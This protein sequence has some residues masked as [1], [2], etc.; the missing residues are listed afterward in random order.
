[1][2]ISEDIKNIMTDYVFNQKKASDRWADY[3]NRENEFDL[4][5][6]IQDSLIKMDLRIVENTKI[7]LDNQLKSNKTIE[8]Q[9]EIMKEL[10][11]VKQKKQRL[12]NLLL[13]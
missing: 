12:E 4:K 8:E 3:S 10:K 7:Q 6:N 5:R 2:E 1:M 13:R 9:L 11:L